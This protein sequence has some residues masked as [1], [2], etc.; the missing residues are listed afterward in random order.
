MTY[1]TLA[2]LPVIKAA[3]TE[4]AP[5]VE[6]FYKHRD[7]GLRRDI[8]DGWDRFLAQHGHTFGSIEEILEKHYVKLG[9]FN[10]NLNEYEIAT[11]LLQGEIYSPN[12]EAKDILAP[13]DIAHTTFYN[14][15]ILR[16]KGAYYFMDDE[17]GLICI[18]YVK[19]D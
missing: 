2:E 9:E 13:L 1:Q 10:T 4:G 6:V 3:S 19:K 16:M 18:G 5:L 17:D 14:G 8:M 12:G 15:D 11:R 7:S